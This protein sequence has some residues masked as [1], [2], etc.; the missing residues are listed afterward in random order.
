VNQNHVIGHL[1]L[2]LE[3]AQGGKFIPRENLALIRGGAAPSEKGLTSCSFG[4]GLAPMFREPPVCDIVVSVGIT[5]A[6]L[7]VGRE[8]VI[9]RYKLVRLRKG[10]GILAG[11]PGP[12]ASEEESFVLDLWLLLEFC[13]SISAA[14]EVWKKWLSILGVGVSLAIA[15]VVNASGIGTEDN[16]E[17]AELELEL[18]LELELELLDLAGAAGGGFDPPELLKPPFEDPSREPPFGAR[19]S[20]SR[21]V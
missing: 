2:T 21:P 4:V 17:A 15:V 6:L 13:D 18:A 20:G 12:T 11:P 8:H 9:D 10:F 5:S 1:T 16:E 3:S 14:L 19:F 7:K